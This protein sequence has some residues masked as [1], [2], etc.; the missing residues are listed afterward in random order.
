MLN[1]PYSPMPSLSLFQKI[2]FTLSAYPFT[3][4]YFRT[5][6]YPTPPCLPT[7]LLFLPCFVLPV[8]FLPH[9]TR[10]NS[11]G[12]KVVKLGRVYY[13]SKQSTVMYIWYSVRLSSPH[14]SAQYTIVQWPKQNECKVTHTEHFTAITLQ[15]LQLLFSFQFPSRCL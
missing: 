7:L 12:S 5:L 2:P 1:L 9:K 6:L 15:W 4:L 8:L 10:I 13:V 14:L 3:A 11:K